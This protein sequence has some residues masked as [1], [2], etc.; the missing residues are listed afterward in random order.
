MLA[1]QYLT[2]EN[3][4]LHEISLLLGYSEQSAFQRAF[5]Q[6]TRQ[7]PQQW[8]SDYLKNKTQEKFLDY[9]ISNLDF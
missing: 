3:L 6:W 2:D 1:Q 9:P 5:K 8:R 7:T 4:S